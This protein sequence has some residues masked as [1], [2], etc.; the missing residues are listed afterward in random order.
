MS[1]ETAKI[2]G[3]EKNA[4]GKY[5]IKG[6]PKDDK[7]AGSGG[8]GSGKSTP[9]V[10]KTDN[11]NDVYSK[12]IGIEEQLD[13]YDYVPQ[14]VRGNIKAS[15]AGIINTELGKEENKLTEDQ[16]INQIIPATIG[17]GFTYID[18][19]WGT[20]FAVPTFL[21]NADEPVKAEEL[22]QLGY[23]KKQVESIMEYINRQ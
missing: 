20:D 2:F 6:K 21:L 19:S 15:I 14:A 22:T 1:A 10:E 16:L 8:S 23:S 13:N 11:F 12:T 17:Q 7:K 5:I 18:A 9:N 3:V 4:D